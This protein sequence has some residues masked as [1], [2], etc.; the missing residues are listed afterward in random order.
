M[1]AGSETGP[2][3]PRQAEVD[4]V[5]SDRAMACRARVQAC[6]V[7]DRHPPLSGRSVPVRG[8]SHRRVRRPHGNSLAG[9]LNTP[10]KS[11]HRDVGVSGSG[12]DRNGCG[13]GVL[14]A[15]ALAGAP[16][17]CDA[18]GGAGKAAGAAGGAAAERGPG[19]L[20]RRTNRGSVGI[21]AAAVGAG[22]GAE[23]RDAAAQGARRRR[24]DP[25]APPGLRDPCW[26]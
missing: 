17:R 12:N 9:G 19:G 1:P 15:G 25:H 7:E 6:D 13:D 3:G 4:H 18:A 21:R 16:G 8:A 10:L 24:A 20:T 14:P 26:R 11:D 23:P 22:R 5:L 2:A